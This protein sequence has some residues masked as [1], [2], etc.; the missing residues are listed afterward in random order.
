LFYNINPE[1]CTN[2]Q[3]FVLSFSGRPPAFVLPFPEC[4]IPVTLLICSVGSTVGKGM[5]LEEAISS[6]VHGR[7]GPVF[8][9][10]PIFPDS[11]DVIISLLSFLT[12][13]NISFL[14]KTMP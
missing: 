4:R 12:F 9:V 10:E 8:S 1:S 7:L 6:S 11:S 2:F 14:P 5:G 13:V 3:H